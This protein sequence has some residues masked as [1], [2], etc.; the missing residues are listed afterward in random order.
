MRPS[1]VSSRGEKAS[2]PGSAQF[3]LWRGP[4][5]PARAADGVWPAT[6]YPLHY[7]AAAGSTS[8][9]L[10]TH[11]YPCGLDHAVKRAL[12]VPGWLS[13]VDDQ[14]LFGDRRADLRRWRAEIGEWLW[15]ERGLK[16]KHPQARVLSC[17]GTLDALGYRITRTSIT[18]RARTLR[19][20]EARMRRAQHDA[21]APA[22][23][24][25]RRSI[26]ASV[27]ATLFQ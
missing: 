14:L 5:S 11:V 27:G 7:R 17:A 25:L 10:V 20:L 8:Q 6:R 21:G 1:C 13:Y 24:G 3:T 22:S 12:K 4:P 19:R 23:E 9:Y 18:A 16:L 26:A 2:P 15:R